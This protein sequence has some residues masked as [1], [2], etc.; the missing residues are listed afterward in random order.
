MAFGEYTLRKKKYLQVDVNENSRL[1][2]ALK[3]MVLEN[4][5]KNTRGGV[6]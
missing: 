3:K 6:A 2:S 4:R 1:V 5:C